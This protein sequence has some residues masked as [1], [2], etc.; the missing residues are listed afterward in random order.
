[1]KGGARVHC[2]LMSPTKDSGEKRRERE[3]ERERERG[4]GRERERE[5][6]HKGIELEAIW[7]PRD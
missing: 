4:G 6:G 1:M 5:S 7:Y 2:K 3:R